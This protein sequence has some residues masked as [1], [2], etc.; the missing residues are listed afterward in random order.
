MSDLTGNLFMTILPVKTGDSFF[1]HT[2]LHILMSISIDPQMG[3]SPFTEVVAAI[4]ALY[5]SLGE[6]R[7]YSLAHHLQGKD[8]HTYFPC[9][10]KMLDA[11]DC[12]TLPTGKFQSV[13]AI[14]YDGQLISTLVSVPTKGKT[15]KAVIKEASQSAEFKIWLRKFRAFQD[16]VDAS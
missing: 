6:E 1:N 15:Y 11:C 7:Q 8:G 2:V 4:Q 13:L 12:L 14:T 16:E 3:S 9:D 10:C 5:P